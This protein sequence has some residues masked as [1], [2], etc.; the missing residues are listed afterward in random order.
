MPSRQDEKT[1][2]LLSPWQH[3][4]STVALCCV[5]FTHSYLLIS[6]FPYRYEHTTNL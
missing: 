6:V 4:L 3:W 2:L 1:H 5:A